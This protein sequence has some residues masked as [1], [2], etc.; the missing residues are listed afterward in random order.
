MTKLW[1]FS[2]GHSKPAFSEKVQR[3]DQ[4]KFFKTPQKVAFALVADKDT[5]ANGII[6]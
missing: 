1:E 5:R 2:R 3:E 4:G 6:F